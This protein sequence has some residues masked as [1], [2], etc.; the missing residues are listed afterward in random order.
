M[1]LKLRFYQLNRYVYFYGVLVLA[2]VMEHCNGIALLFCFCVS[3]EFAVLFLVC[4]CGSVTCSALLTVWI[5]AQSSS[6]WIVVF[7]SIVSA[8][9]PSR[10]Y[11]FRFPSGT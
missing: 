1:N 7:L 5:I 2:F 6:D 3:I 8:L 9:F 10:W 11:C 4:V